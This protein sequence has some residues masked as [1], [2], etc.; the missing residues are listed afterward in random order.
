MARRA[1]EGQ[2]LRVCAVQAHRRC[3]RVSETAG[4]PIGPREMADPG[5]K[6][7]SQQRGN[8]RPTM[9]CLTLQGFL[10]GS[11]PPVLCTVRTRA[12]C[13]SPPRCPSHECDPA[14][15]DL[16]A[17]GPSPSRAGGPRAQP[18]AAEPTLVGRALWVFIL[19]PARL[20][21]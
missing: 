1:H 18:F 14:G 19:L 8:A 17:S 6:A 2:V 11:H 12:P 21:R 16:E 15:G 3:S 9:L 5:A 4:V 10:A 7:S 13:T 20:S